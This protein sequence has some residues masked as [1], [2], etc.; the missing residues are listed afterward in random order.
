LSSATLVRS[1]SDA[2]LHPFPQLHVLTSLSSR[3]FGPWRPDK[4]VQN[5]CGFRRGGAPARTC[6]RPRPVAGQ[7][8]ADL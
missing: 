6:P 8:G 7:S 3:A 4:V 2:L 1:C 5:C